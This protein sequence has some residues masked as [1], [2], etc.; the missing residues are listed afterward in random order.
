MGDGKTQILIKET[1]PSWL[2]LDKKKTVK[3]PI[4]ET[5]TLSIKWKVTYPEK[6]QLL[7]TFFRTTVVR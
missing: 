1:H 5:R 3:R 4:Y 6:K 2:E 7:A